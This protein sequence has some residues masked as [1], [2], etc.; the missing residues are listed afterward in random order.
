M[1]CYVSTPTRVLLPGPCLA[2]AA[3]KYSSFAIVDTGA[4]LPGI[5]TDDHDRAPQH[6]AFLIPTRNS[7]SASTGTR[8][9]LGARG[10]EVSQSSDG[11]NNNLNNNNNPFSSRN[12]LGKHRPPLKKAN[13]SPE[14]LKGPQSPSKQ[15]YYRKASSTLEQ[16]QSAKTI[17]KL[18][19]EYELQLMKAG[20]STS[21]SGQ[22]V[23]QPSF[24]SG[25]ATPARAKTLNVF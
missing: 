9:S 25:P 17:K 1:K 4:G 18:R 7:S 20:G 24:A 23:R 8:S 16:K 11:Y 15:Q 3:G 19:S 21:Y 22:V 13:T 12:A 14:K 10:S 5:D 2:V 6:S